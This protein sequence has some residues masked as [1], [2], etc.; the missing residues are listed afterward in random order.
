MATR[1]TRATIMVPR[2]LRALGVAAALLACGT[3]STACASGERPG[4]PR[5]QPLTEAELM[6][7]LPS[8]HDLPGYAA[9]PRPPAPAPSPAA[10]PNALAPGSPAQCADLVD[11]ELDHG[12]R[13]RPA[14]R[15]VADVSPRGNPSG[16]PP[17]RR[18]RTLHSV[19]LASHTVGEASGVMDSLRKAVPLCGT[20]VAYTLAY[21]G[22]DARIRVGALPAPAAGDE[23]VAFD[24]T[25]EGNA[26]DETVPL[27]V[28][29]TG[30]VIAV[31][32][33]AV[34]AGIPQGQHR[35]LRAFLSGSP[36]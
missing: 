12:L 9:T 16:G 4:A 6:S 30:G 32:S 33:G 14:A 5:A 20:F 15:V 26:M 7:V 2:R 34:P 13:H 3:V 8:G 35:R 21:G 24:W 36:G 23:A 27:T 17:Q 28:V 1:A 25:V 19:S 18:F 10:V 11:F 22:Q 31:Y 29:R